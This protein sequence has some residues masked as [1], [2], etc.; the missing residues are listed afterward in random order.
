MEK[1]SADLVVKLCMAL[2]T[3]FVAYTNMP[4]FQALL[5]TFVWTAIVYCILDTLKQW[6]NE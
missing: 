2:F 5:H 4:T 3:I 1:H 6:W